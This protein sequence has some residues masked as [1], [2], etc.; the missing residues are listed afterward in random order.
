VAYN[1]GWPWNGMISMITPE[2]VGAVPDYVTPGGTVLLNMPWQ[3][4]MTFSRQ[5]WAAGGRVVVTTTSQESELSWHSQTPGNNNETSS[6]KLIWIDLATPRPTAEEAAMLGVDNGT[7]QLQEYVFPELGGVALGVIARNGDSR[8]AAAPDWSHGGGNIVYTS[9]S[10]AQDG[11][12][13]VMNDT[14]VYIV[15]FN[16]GAGGEASPVSDAAQPGVAEYYPDFSADDALVAFNR[17]EN[18]ASLQGDIYARAEG[19][20]WIASVQQGAYTAAEGEVTEGGAIRLRANDPHSCGNERSP[21]LFNSWPKWSPAAWHVDETGLTYYWLIFSSGREARHQFE[22]DND[23][24]EKDSRYTQ[25]YMA[26]ITVQ[27]G[28]V[29]TYPAIYLWNQDQET[30]NYTP[31]WDDFHIPEVP[32]PVEVW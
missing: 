10:S 8:A 26:P 9:T 14:D 30:S 1:D 11:R 12:I 20:I 23:N 16:N 21:G 22:P 24:P 25:L 4:I 5:H 27:D 2:Q 31:A 15:P 19:E 6:T 17:I 3:G 28:Q 18:S 29:T 7:W 32:P 13:G